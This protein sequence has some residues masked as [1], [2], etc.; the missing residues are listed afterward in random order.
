MKV[1]T[2][3]R[4]PKGGHSYQVFSIVRDVSPRTVSIRVAAGKTDATVK[5]CLGKGQAPALI[6]TVDQEVWHHDISKAEARTRLAR[7]RAAATHH[8]YT[9][10]QA[11]IQEK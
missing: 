8:G 7:W 6:A 4:C 2:E 1:T 3:L 5:R 11:F 9:E 10:A